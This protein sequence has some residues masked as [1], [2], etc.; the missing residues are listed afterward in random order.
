MKTESLMTFCVIEDDNVGLNKLVLHYLEAVA[1]AGD[2]AVQ[3]R[4]LKELIRRYVELENKVDALLKNTL[5]AKVADEIKYEGL[6]VPR[7]YACTIIFSDLIGFTKLAEDISGTMLIDMLN[8]IFISFDELISTYRGTKIKTIGDA[9]MSVFGAPY[10]L[11]NH[12]I[13]AVRAGLALQKFI[14]DFNRQNRCNLQMRLGIH[15]GSVMAG[16]VG[17]ERMQFDVFGDDVNIASR[18]ESSGEAGKVNISE[19]TYHQLAGSFEVQERGMIGLK[20]KKNMKAYFVTKEIR[21]E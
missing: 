3:K 18:F 11:E 10:P 2:N 7:P 17:K 1:V 5:P 15:T 21:P 16:V 4:I 6:F 20:N 12:A 8:R 19:T 9:Y 13:Q 14:L